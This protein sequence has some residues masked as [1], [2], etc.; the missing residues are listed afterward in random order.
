[1]YIDL[2]DLQ[3]LQQLDSARALPDTV[4]YHRQFA[5]GW[6]LAGKWPSILPAGEIRH[7]I[8]LAT[9][10]G[11][12]ASVS[13]LQSYLFDELRVPLVLNQGYTIPAWVDEH[14]LAIV[15]SH[16]GNTEE[17]LSAYDLA[18]AVGAK[19]VVITA[20]GKLLTRA[21]EKSHPVLIIPGGMMP[22][23]AL[24]YIFLPLLGLLQQLGLVPDKTAEVR[25]TIALLKVL[26]GHYGPAIP[27]KNNLAK[28][29]AMEMDGYVPIIYGSLPLTDAIAWRW[30]NQMGEN[31]KLIAMY[32]AI[33]NL[34][35]DEAV[36]W[37]APSAY[38][39]RFYF[40]F[41]RDIEDSDKIRRRLAT[42][43]EILHH[44]AA[45]VREVSSQGESRLA[46]LFSLVYL[47]DFITLYLA[48]IRGV[49]PTPVE[50]IDLF[51]RKMA[52]GE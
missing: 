40:T 50:V 49:D 25:E 38:L 13:L 46:R 1:M 5:D 47:G 36:G 22:R 9:G 41:L 18:A 19:A 33:P 27:A 42:S 21:R 26:A 20:G 30:K 37:D 15:V 2:D 48:L 7:I 3:A 16:S 17:I 52:A 35:H 28:T 6:E 11:S 44:R 51:K 29:M 4:D 10:G 32:N 43:Q 24:G 12:A 45:G 14:T 31:S 39:K 34:H 8:V 23:I